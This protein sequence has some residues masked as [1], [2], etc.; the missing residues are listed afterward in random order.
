MQCTITNCNTEEI[1]ITASRATF[2]QNLE[3]L[4]LLLKLA[5]QFEFRTYL[6]QSEGPT[7][8]GLLFKM[9]IMVQLV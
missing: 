5:T 7:K 6:A 3:Y 1:A 8:L 4:Q 2:E 9:D